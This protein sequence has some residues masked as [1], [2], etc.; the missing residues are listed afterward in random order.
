M[1]DILF[2]NVPQISLVY[3]PAA[4]SLLKGICEHHGYT[5]QVKDYNLKLYNE[6]IDPDLAQQLDHYF[7]LNDCE[8]ALPSPAE[9]YLDSYI[10][11]IIVE[12]ININP[13]FLAI[14]VF[15]FQCQLFTRQLLTQLRPVFKNKIVVG[16]AGLSSTGIAS[17]QNDFGTELLDKGLVDYFIRGEGDYAIIN[18][19]EGNIGPGINNDQSVQIDNLDEIPYPNYDDVINLGYQYTTGSPQIPVTGSRGCIRKCSFCD[20]H[21]AWKKYRY[22]SGINVAKEFIHHYQ[23]YNVKN[24]WFTDSLINGSMKS[25]REFCQ[26]LIKFYKE[27]NLPL[28]YFNWGGQFIVRDCQSM[29]ASDYKLAAEAG[30]NGV[31]MGVE[32]LSENVR[33]HMKKGFSNADLDYTLE[34]MHANDMNCYFLMIVGYP[35][36]TQEEFEHSIQKFIEYKKYALDGTIY[37]VNL[38]STI[39]IDEG[40]PLWHQIDE[41]DMDPTR[42]NLGYDWYSLSNPSLTFRE[43][44]R[45]RIVLQ[46]KLMELGYKIWNGDSQLLKLQEAYQKINDR[47]YKV[48]INLPIAK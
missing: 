37:G 18:L 40:T 6:C 12:I 9:Q 1:I 14:S 38:G 47:K 45:R 31:A 17:L 3:P 5:A 10:K 8:S 39:S 35:T 2:I 44:I 32:S 26:C 46:E 13:K 43:R 42:D 20:I 33:E 27:N 28:K 36:E 4:T 7:S 11:E 30:M 24:F 29:T 16:G 22:R 19:L 21:V 34:Q 25:F 41:L 48:K 15:T 23:N